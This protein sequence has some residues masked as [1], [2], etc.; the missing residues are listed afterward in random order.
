MHSGINSINNTTPP[1]VPPTIA[2]VLVAS[3]SEVVS[4]IATYMRRV[5]IINNFILMY[6]HTYVCVYRY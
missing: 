3:S 6:L 5:Q 4:P 2:A 1:T